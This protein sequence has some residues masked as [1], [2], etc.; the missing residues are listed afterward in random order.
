MYA[1][2]DAQMRADQDPWFYDGSKLALRG[3]ERDFT[4]PFVAVLGGSET[5][6]KHVALPYP[7][8]LERRIGMPVANLGVMHAGVS[9]FSKERWL[10]DIASQAE[11]TVIQVMGAQNMSNRL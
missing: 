7:A 5:F 3:P 9:L 1:K 8:L 10:L 11:L 6:G 4:R 2:P